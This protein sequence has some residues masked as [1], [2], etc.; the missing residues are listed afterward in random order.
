MSYRKTLRIITAIIVMAA[1]FSTPVRTAAQT[2]VPTPVTISKDKVRVDGVICYSHIVLERQTLY[3]ISKAYNVSIEELYKYNPDLK[4]EGLKKNGILLIPVQEET[5]AQNQKQVKD[6]GEVKRNDNSK[7]IEIKSEKKSS[8]KK[9][10]KVHIVKWYEDLNV[11]AGKYGVSVEDLMKHNGLKN[12]RLKSRQKLLIPEAGEIIDIP[13]SDD[14]ETVVETDAQEDT[15]NRQ[16]LFP[17]AK[18]EQK[19]PVEKNDIKVALILPFN[20]S[21]TTSNRGSMDFYSGVLMAASEAAENGINIDLNVIDIDNEIAPTSESFTGLDIAI[22]PISIL[23]IKEALDVAPDSL[24]FISP[25]DPR[26]ESLA[27]TR[28]N[29]IHA[30]ASQTSQYNDLINWVIEEK[31]PEDNLIY[32]S[33]QGARSFG[34][35]AQMKSL[36]DSSKVDYKKFSY[37]ILDGREISDTLT[38][39]MAGNG[40]NRVVIASESEAFVNDVV[41]NLNLLI[42]NKQNI[43]LY[44]SSKIRS[45][46]TIDVENFHDASLRVSQSYYIDYNDKRVMDFLMKYRALYNNEPSQFAFCG[47]DIASYFFEIIHKYGDEWKD[48]LGKVEAE[49]LQARFS[50]IQTRSGGWKNTGIRRSKYEKGWKVEFIPKGI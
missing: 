19:I 2:Y 36:L 1:A 15:I 20:A 44:G 49:K 42:Y 27:E 43:T 33:E 23:D 34:S 14:S 28:K 45:F 12:R 35:V 9:D 29:L 16:A 6:E 8:K 30:P 7:K 47:Y 31:K 26:A 11:I 4:E 22:G 10:K 25:L 18:E 21:G 38:A 46:E 24:M 3:S 50:F 5:V 32:I 13:A 17:L 37:S 41:R 40:M 48:S 39:L